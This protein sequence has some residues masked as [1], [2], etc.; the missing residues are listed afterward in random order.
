MTT[1]S[2]YDSELF[3]KELEGL[4]NK[5]LGQDS[6]GKIRA[7]AWDQFLEIGLPTKQEEAYKY[8]K[9]R[10]LYGEAFF[11]SKVSDVKA[12]DLQHHILPE[13]QGSC[14]VLVNGFYQPHLSRRSRLPER[15][16]VAL[17]SDAP[18]TFGAFLNNQWPKAIREETDP[19]AILNTALHRDGLFLYLAPK[20]ILEVPLQVLH[21][22]DPGQ[23]PML[24]SPRIQLFAGAQSQVEVVVTYAELSGQ[25]YF[26][27]QS[28][29]VIVEEDA[30]FKL[31][32][33]NCKASPD[34][35]YFDAF[36]A[37]MKKN[38]TLKVVNVNEGGAVLRNDYRVALKGENGEAS[39]NGVLMLKDKREA[40]THVVIDHQA[41]HCRSRQLFKGVLNDFGN[42]SFEGKILVRQA[43][44]K[45][46][47]FQLN[48][49]LL[50]SD[51]ANADSKPNLEIFADDVKA[52]H[53]A[54]V[55][56]LDPEQFFYMKTRGLTD[57]EAQSFLIGGFCQEVS[58][59]LLVPSIKEAV[60]S[61]IKNFL[62]PR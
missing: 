59:L 39:L 29:D 4:Y 1:S 32:H 17:L 61:R 55:G 36:R 35:W 50:L 54:T 30:H 40:H 37:V 6:L 22:L 5:L 31:S 27:N 9:L 7:A 52:S 19:F 8:I 48:N 58:D 53:G 38:S 34:A 42:S 15:M 33:V 51:R 21:I 16:T 41:P 18:K 62:N 23:D 44:D 14:L 25:R 26:V 45:T 11:P 28:M 12:V 57:A 46:D 2:F 56:Q 20:T 10:K 47:A 13:C 24:M 3:Q 43:A 60:E 49:N